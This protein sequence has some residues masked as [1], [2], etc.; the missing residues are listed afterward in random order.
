MRL[1]VRIFGQKRDRGEDLAGLAIAALRRVRLDPGLL[2]GVQRVR[3]EALDGRHRLA[4]DRADRRLAG[5]DRLAVDQYGAGAAQA[6]AAAELRADQAKFVAQR[7]QERHFH[8]GGSI[9]REARRRV[10]GS[11]RAAQF[12]ISG[13]STG[14]FPPFGR[15]RRKSSPKRPGIRGVSGKNSLLSRAG[16][17]FGP[18]GNSKSLF[19]R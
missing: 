1:P 18:S 6:G 11:R 4:R 12:P 3:A 10:A 15:I 5:A 16:R 13:K 14:N 2:H 9:R 17:L 7:P 8:G 19:D